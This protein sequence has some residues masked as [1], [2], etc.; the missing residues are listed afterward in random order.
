MPVTG[1][2]DLDDGLELDDSFMAGPSS[3]AGSVIEDEAGELEVNNQADVLAD[4]SEEVDEN[5]G[6]IADSQEAHG[7]QSSAA[8][9]T[10][11]K[12]EE[13][14]DDDAVLKAERKRRRKEKEKE[15]KAKVRGLR[16]TLL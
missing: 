4:E 7:K 1:G 9:G 11:R 15:R 12:A 8:G 10:K 5:E 14:Q 13:N 3:S 2:D 16:W 6:D